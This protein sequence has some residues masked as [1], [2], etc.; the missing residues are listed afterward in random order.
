MTFINR[1]MWQLVRLAKMA[2]NS[3]KNTYF[4]FKN[5]IFGKFCEICKNWFL[6]KVYYFRTRV[7]LG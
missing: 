6:K 3:F 5:R 2:K 4:K 1:I 7:V